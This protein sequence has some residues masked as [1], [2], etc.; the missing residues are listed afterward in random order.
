MLFQV[1]HA[2]GFIAT[3]R[4]N[5]P[6]SCFLERDPCLPV[7]LSS[8]WTPAVPQG[9][10]GKQASLC[11]P[12][13]SQHSHNGEHVNSWLGWLLQWLKQIRGSFATNNEFCTLYANSSL[14]S[15]LFLICASMVLANLLWATKQVTKPWRLLVFYYK[16]SVSLTL[17]KTCLK[18]ELRLHSWT[19]SGSCCLLNPIIFNTR[20]CPL[21]CNVIK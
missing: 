4:T 15:L 7:C 19:S 8:V 14:L 18:A 9:V 11:L 13:P 10:S 20:L 3:I 16:L 1:A 17:H 12:F 2:S 6:C 5:K 21:I